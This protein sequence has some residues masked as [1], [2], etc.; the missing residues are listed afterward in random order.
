MLEQLIETIVNYV[1]SHPSAVVVPV[2]ALITYV[3]VDT[4]FQNIKMNRMHSTKNIKRISLPP[5]IKNSKEIIF[6]EEMMKKQLSEFI[7]EFYS[8]VKRELNGNDLNLLNT[9]LSSLFI[10]DK[11]VDL[12]SSKFKRIIHKLRFPK[13]YLVIAYYDVDRN[14]IIINEEN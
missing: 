3:N 8:T 13:E 7:K 9:N 12:E 1:V 6:D 10:K 4:V 11:N 2:S 14:A 5:E